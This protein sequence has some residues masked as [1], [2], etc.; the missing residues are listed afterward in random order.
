MANLKNIL[1]VNAK[2][3]K[4]I[5][6]IRP[7]ALFAFQSGRSVKRLCY[8]LKAICALNPATI[9]KLIAWYTK[10]PCDYK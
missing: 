1:P 7:S 9:E 4:K 2:K 5:R 3:P 10:K 6:E 8:S